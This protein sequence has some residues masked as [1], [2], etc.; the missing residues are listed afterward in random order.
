MVHLAILTL[1]GQS[2]PQLMSGCDTHCP[3]LPLVSPTPARGE[4]R[5]RVLGKEEGRTCLF[6][7][8]SFPI[9]SWEEFVFLIFKPL[10]PGPVLISEGNRGY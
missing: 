5:P 2:Q 4:R 7:L 3:Q 10:Y 1:S 6:F 9:C 8:L